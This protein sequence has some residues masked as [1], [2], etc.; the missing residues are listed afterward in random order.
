MTHS[1][2]TLTKTPPPARDFHMF[3]PLVIQAE[4][5]DLFPDY[6]RKMEQQAAAIISRIDA[7]LKPNPSRARII[8]WGTMPATTDDPKALQLMRDHIILAWPEKVCGCMVPEAGKLPASWFLVFEAM[9]TFTWR[10]LLNELKAAH[11][12]PSILMRYHDESPAWHVTDVTYWAR[13]RA[14]NWD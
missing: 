12:L 13:Y 6:A 10:R 5:I 11:M 9:S 4:Q 7:T 3:A 14:D 2:T 1:L 8:L